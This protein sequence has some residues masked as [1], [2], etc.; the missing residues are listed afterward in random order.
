MKE[1]G[2]ERFGTQDGRGMDEDKGRMPR[3]PKKNA[4]E[5]LP[6]AGKPYQMTTFTK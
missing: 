4:E 2:H 1:R 6:I 3:P 5:V